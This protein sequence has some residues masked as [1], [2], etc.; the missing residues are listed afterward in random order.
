MLGPLFVAFICRW[1]FAM[2]LPPYLWRTLAV[3]LAGGLNLAKAR[4][5]CRQAGPPARELCQCRRTGA[6]RRQLQNVLPVPPPAH[7]PA[8]LRAGGA[9]QGRHVLWAGGADGARR[10]RP[11]P[12]PAVRA[13]PGGVHG[14]GAAHGGAADGG[15]HPVDQLRRAGGAVRRTGAGA[16]AAGVAPPAAA[17]VGGVGGLGWGSGGGNGVLQVWQGGRRCGTARFVFT[18]EIPSPCCARCVAALAPHSACLPCAA[19]RSGQWWQPWPSLSTTA[20]TWR[21]S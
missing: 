18:S 15:G 7:P 21:S 2:P 11:R 17:Q 9:G 16:G 4:C 5:A 8:R 10:R 1:M 20:P 3:M 13:E 12:G 19:R 6:T 14:A